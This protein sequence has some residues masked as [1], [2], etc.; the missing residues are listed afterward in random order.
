M[1][2][3]TE[4]TRKT[5]SKHSDSRE[6]VHGVTFLLDEVFSILHELP[7]CHHGVVVNVELVVG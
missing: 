4:N 2:W 6:E 5:L 7:Q 1:C 3:S